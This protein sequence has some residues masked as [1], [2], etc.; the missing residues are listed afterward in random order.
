M[1]HHLIEVTAHIDDL[2]AT[3][4]TLLMMSYIGSLFYSWMVR[5]KE[6]FDSTNPER[7]KRHPSVY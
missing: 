4:Y 7:T 6:V 1:S 3:I 2:K 5:E